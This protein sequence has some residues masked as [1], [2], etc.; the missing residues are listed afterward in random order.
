MQQP[1]EGVKELTLQ[2]QNDMIAWLIHESDRF[3]KSNCRKYIYFLVQQW[4]GLNLVEIGGS[5]IVMEQVFP[6]MI[7]NY[8]TTQSER[9]I[10]LL[11]VKQFIN[12]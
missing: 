6:E 12:T 4:Y 2:Q 7:S 1:E 5:S 8:F 10:Y 11:L 3:K 9:I